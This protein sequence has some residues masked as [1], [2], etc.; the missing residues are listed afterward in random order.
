M[1]TIILSGFGIFGN[2]LNN[3]SKTVAKRL[4]GRT[5]GNFKFLT[6]VFTAQ[7][8][9]YN[10][11][12]ILF[13]L[14]R[15]NSALGIISLGVASEKKGLCVE[16]RARNLFLNEKYCPELSGKPV[17]QKKKVAEQL[18]LDLFP[19]NVPSFCENC[20]SAG[21]AV[22]V[23]RDCGGFCC[24]QLAYQSRV[25][26]LEMCP[27]TTVPYIFMHIPCARE[28]VPDIVDFTMQGKIVMS[29]E[30]I[31]AGLSILLDGSQL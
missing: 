14:A 28:D 12:E 20:S 18:E 16:T 30:Q 22:E 15:S 8:S 25:Y 31:I 27:R 17:D 13:E 4:D 2:Y 21:I 3:L 24:N 19:W 6:M 26:Q 9:N 1:K 5:I 10:R 29:S 7:I 11:G 23:S